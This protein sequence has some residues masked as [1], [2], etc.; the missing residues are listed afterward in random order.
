MAIVLQ[1]EYE[2]DELGLSARPRFAVTEDT[3]LE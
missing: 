1:G 2:I 3:T